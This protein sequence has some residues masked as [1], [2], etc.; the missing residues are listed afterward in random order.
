MFVDLE[1]LLGRL[2]RRHAALIR[3]RYGVGFSISET[4]E[5]LGYPHDSI[6]KMTLVVVA[7]LRRELSERSPRSTC[8]GLGGR[9]RR[10]TGEERAKI[11][12]NVLSERKTVAAV[13]RQYGIGRETV[14]KILAE[15]RERAKSNALTGDPP[16]LAE[17]KPSGRLVAS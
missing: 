15:L 5:R 7:R 11:A 1:R 2:R 14:E 3:L 8:A 4:A 6:R 16:T 12:E 10:L 13:T 17:R 9:R